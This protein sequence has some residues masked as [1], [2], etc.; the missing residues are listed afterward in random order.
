MRAYHVTPHPDREE[1]FAV[2][3]PTA[4]RAKYIGFLRFCDHL[5]DADYIDVRVRW[6]RNADL[7]GLSP[8]VVDDQ[9]EITEAL[10]RGLYGCA[11]YTDCPACGSKLTHVWHENGRFWCTE[12]FQIEMGL[13]G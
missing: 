6:L 1:G 9:L 4:K 3:A 11:E 8:G 10:H 12:C 5:D 13:S 7:S 2:I